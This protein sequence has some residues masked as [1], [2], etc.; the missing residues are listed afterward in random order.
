MTLSYAGKHILKFEKETNNDMTNLET[1]SEQNRLQL[2]KEKQCTY[3]LNTKT[4]KNGRSAL[5]HEK[6]NK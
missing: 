3:I 2:I 6:T 5:G 4:K 1:W